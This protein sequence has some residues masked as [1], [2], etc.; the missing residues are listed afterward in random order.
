MYKGSI[1]R[2]CGELPGCRV[3]LAVVIFT[4]ACM[5][6]LAAQTPSTGS[7]TGIAL[8]QSSAVV[9]GVVVSLSIANS[10]QSQTAV[11]DD[12]GRFAFVP[13]R[14]GIYDIHASKT[15]FKELKLLDIRVHVTETLRVELHLQSSCGN[16]EAPA[17]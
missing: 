2:Y 10:S 7:V 15:G 14:P 9:P 5:E 4:F 3:C 6:R 16:L 12:L 11:S 8:D 17:Y 1:Q 13:V